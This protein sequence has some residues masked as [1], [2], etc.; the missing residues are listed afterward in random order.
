MPDDHA[1]SPEPM[2]FNAGERDRAAR[3][4]RVLLPL[5]LPAALDYLAP[6]GI[7]PPEAGSFVRVPLARR[8]V[9]GVVWDG[10][11]DW[12]PDDRLKPI[13]ETLP[14]TPLQPELRRFVDRVAAYTMTP[15]GSVLRM[16]MSIPDALKPSRPQRLCALS[17]AGAAALAGPSAEMRLT[18]A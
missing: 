3:R 7:S 14:T 15:P 13:I 16:A 4:V 10:E 1:S 11:G 9:T 8:S 2:T 6:A 18:P 12:L 5:P 17:S